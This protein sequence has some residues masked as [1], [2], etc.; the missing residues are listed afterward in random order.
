MPDRDRDRRLVALCRSA[1]E[2]RREKGQSP[3]VGQKAW[4]RQARWGS[5]SQ[6]GPESMGEAGGVGQMFLT[7]GHIL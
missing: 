5:V 6:C 4:G 3:S 2:E 7:N 1:G